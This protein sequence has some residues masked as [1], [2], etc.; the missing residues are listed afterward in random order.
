MTKLTPLHALALS[1][2]GDLDKY[3]RLSAELGIDDD[4]LDVSN[5]SPSKL[6]ALSPLELE[7]LIKETISNYGVQT[8][9][10]HPYSALTNTVSR[11]KDQP[12]TFE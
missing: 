6:A 1:C 2:E 5:Q 9:H 7:G 10:D 8:I 3:K 4:P 12:E 11:K